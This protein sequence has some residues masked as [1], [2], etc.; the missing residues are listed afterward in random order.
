LRE[1]VAQAGDALARGIAEVLDRALT[2]KRAHAGTET[3]SAEAQAIEAALREMRTID[4]RIADVRQ[5]IWE[6]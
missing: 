4:E 3:A 5:T 2:E 6:T 1:F